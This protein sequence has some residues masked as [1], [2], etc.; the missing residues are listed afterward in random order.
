MPTLVVDPVQFARAATGMTEVARS[1]QSAASSLAAALS[2]SGGMGGSDHAGVEWS[3]SYDEGARAA[4]S[5]VASAV[6]AAGNVATRLHATGVNHAHADAAATIGGSGDAALPAAPTPPTMAAPS[7]PSAA[8]GSGGGP[9]GWSLVEGLVGYVWPN[10]HQD[11]L[12]AADAAWQATAA[13]LQAAASPV[14][15]AAS[16][17]SAQQSPECGA[18]ATA[19]TE[20][21]AHLSDLASVCTELGSSCSE[22]AAHL[23]QAHH[24]I[25]ST[26]KELIIETAAIE[27]GGA[28]LAFF[29][30]GLDEIAAQALVAARI[31]TAA[32]KIRRVIEALIDAA[33]AV[34]AAVKGFAGR[35]AEVLSKLEPLATGAVKTAATA[36]AKAGRAGASAVADAGRTGASA[37]SSAARAAPSA[38]SNG[39]KTAANAVAEGALKNASAGAGMEFAKEGVESIATGENKLDPTK[40]ASQSAFSMLTGP[41][42]KAVGE[43]TIPKAVTQLGE[44]AK[45]SVVTKGARQVVTTATSASLNA[46]QQELHATISPDT[47]DVVGGT[48]LVQ[49]ARDL[50][51]AWDNA[52]AAIDQGREKLDDAVDAARQKLGQ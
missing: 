3:N 33:R 37:A 44:E 7:P 24:E 34:A 19:C 43:R 39:A 28:V 38:I 47:A 23:D 17:V 46:T 15:G 40:I 11:R 41:V 8:G 22:Y 9:P 20:T 51:E 36:A 48:S 6:G 30:A 26:L 31:A 4:M 25:I 27:A 32:A 13:Q 21:G 52:P 50:P 10:G 18:A 42:G 29:T 35:A 5:A 45:E 49:T 2:G 16:A 14:A 12:H 1:T